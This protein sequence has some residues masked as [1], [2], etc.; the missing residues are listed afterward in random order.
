MIKQI[1]NRYLTI[2]ISPWLT[3][4]KVFNNPLVYKYWQ[5]IFLYFFKVT[6]LFVLCRDRPFRCHLTVINTLDQSCERK[7]R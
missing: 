1:D 6:R 7:L 5:L 2:P 3:K 4:K